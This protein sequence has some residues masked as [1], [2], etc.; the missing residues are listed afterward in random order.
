MIKVGVTGGIG[1]G[2][3]LICKVFEKL[4][5]PVYYADI[6][7]RDLTESDQEIRNCL[8]SLLGEEIY[9]GKSLNRP[10]MASL[11]FKDKQLLN[12]VNQIFSQKMMDHFSSWSDSYTHC[13]Y[14]IN[15]SAILFESKMYLLFDKI[16]TISA[17]EEI[18]IQR[19]LT[20]KDMNREKVKSIMQNQLPENETIQRS[21]YVIINDGLTLVL[22]QIMHIHKSLTISN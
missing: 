22:P 15:E 9:E 21:H 3:S 6:A 17:P 1:S 20:R 2:K 8:I 13:P 10:K 4:G 5:V 19:V 12:S 14:I 16:I 11:I 7:A 18:R